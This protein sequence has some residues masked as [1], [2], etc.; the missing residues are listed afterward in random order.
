LCLPPS[1]ARPNLRVPGRL[2]R[3]S[4]IGREL[5]IERAHESGQSSQRLLRRASGSHIVTPALNRVGARP[6]HSRARGP[7]PGASI[8]P[9]L[10]SRARR[11]QRGRSTRPAPPGRAGEAPSMTSNRESGM[12]S[13]TARQSSGRA[14][15]SRP[16]ARTSVGA[17]ISGTGSSGIAVLLAWSPMPRHGTGRSKPCVAA[18]AGKGASHSAHALRRPRPCPTSS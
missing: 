3:P 5:S 13:A 2:R 6:R 16:P 18:T 10:R 11:R 12:S 7:G 1:R 4:A 15:E 9:G 14:V 8:S 17:E